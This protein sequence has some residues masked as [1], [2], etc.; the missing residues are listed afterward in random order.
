MN[1]RLLK[2]KIVI[3]I[4]EAIFNYDAR[5]QFNKF[6]K[7]NDKI[8]D[9]GALTSPFTKGMNNQVTAI[10]I[11][12][13]DNEFGFS[14][15]TLTKLKNRPNIKSIIMDAQKMEFDD[16]QFDIV[17][18]TEVLEHIPDDKLAAKEI[19]RVLK[20]GGYLFLTVPNLDRVPL[21]HGIKEHYRH[22]K[23]DDLLQ[24]FGSENIILLKDRF[25]FSEFI[26]GSYFI[27]RYNISK[28]KLLLLFLPLE[29]ILKILLVK[30]WLPISEKI[31]PNKP[32]YNLLMVM[33]KKSS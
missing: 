21:E 25:K 24:L 4:A 27:G 17:I 14:K 10:D 2:E 23:K 26:W 8:L 32:G 29:S 16:N 19:I 28:R 3:H 31:F 15:N 33:Q 6:I 5:K 20:P 9:V 7:P 12:P 22:Y 30:I 13:E 1:T 11:L 18:L